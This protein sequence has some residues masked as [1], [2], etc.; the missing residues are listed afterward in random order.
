[1]TSTK[2]ITVHM[3]AETHIDPVWLWPWQDG[4]DTVLATLRS[5]CNLLD[6]FPEFIFSHGE[7]W[8]YKQVEMVDPELFERIRGHVRGGRWEIIGGW[9]MQP[10]CN[11]PSGFGFERQIETGKRYFLDRFGGFPE[12]AVNVDSFGHAAS[13]PG[14]IS[15]AGQKY[16]VMM[17]PQEHEMALPARVFRWRGTPDGPEV[18]TFRIAGSYGAATI[19]P[20]HIARSMSELP[21]GLDQTMCFYGVGDHGGGP[22]AESVRW[23][24]ENRDAIDGCRLVFSSP[25]RF[26]KAIAV[27]DLPV[28]TGELQM[29]A[30]GCYSVERKIKTL[31]RHSEHALRQAEIMRDSGGGAG[32]DD[33]SRIDEAWERV[34]FNHFHDVLAG[35]CL[36]SAYPACYAQLGSAY[37]AA[38]DILTYGLRRKVLSLPDDPLQRMAFFNASDEAYHGYVEFEPWLGLE[39]PW[40]PE[41][42]LL[43][44]RDE[45]IDYQVLRS[46]AVVD[47]MVRLLIHGS[48]EAGEMLSVKIDPAGGKPAG[49]FAG[50]TSEGASNKL[51]AG[52]DLRRRHVQVPGKHRGVTASVGAR[53]GP[54]GHVV[55]RPR[56][57]LGRASGRG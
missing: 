51:G 3:I 46:E 8:T 21:E 20:E 22:T 33:K 38:D 12:T 13:L 1:M 39:G 14:F 17:R 7:A 42:R 44:E 31:V 56:P 5:A 30:I 50:A 4:L 16:Y 32:P 11:L 25:S 53:R 15:A 40:T 10:D 43:N 28:V 49:A 45:S 18:V 23:I 6:E 19:E 26:F 35:T 55:P 2:K 41:H 29:H 34:C 52:F 37:S 9:W 36:P 54:L 24:A 47:G 57:V 27:K 48:L